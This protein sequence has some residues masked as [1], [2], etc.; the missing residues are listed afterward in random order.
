MFGFSQFTVDGEFRSRMAIDHGYKMP[1]KPGTDIVLSFD[2]RTRLRLN[3]K[4]EKFSTRFTLQDARVWGGDNMYNSTGVEGNSDAFGVYEAWVELRLK[5]NNYL[6][7]GRQEWN[8]DDMRILSR[9]NWWAAGLSYD[10]ILFRS[11]NKAE[12]LFLD[13]G[14][15]YNNN[16][17]RIGFVDNSLWPDSKLK[18]M[19][20]LNLKQDFDEKLTASLMFTLAGR[21]IVEDNV[22]LGTGTYGINIKYNKGKSIYNGLF[23]NVSGYYQ[24][25]KDMA[26][27]NGEYKS[28]SAY[29]VAAELGLRALKN[30]F[31]VSVGMELISG[32][33]Y[34]KNDDKYNSVR[35]SFDLLYSARNPYYG[36]HMNY[37]LVQESSK[38]GTKG[39]GY[40]DPYVKLKYV[41]NKKSTVGLAVFRPSLST[42]V[43]STT[44]TPIPGEDVE[45]WKGS[46]GLHFDLG[47]TYKY[48]KE[49]I[50]KFG[51]SYAHVSEMKYEMVYS[52]DYD[53][54]KFDKAKN[55]F[56]WAMLIVKPKFFDSEKRK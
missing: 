19:N 13:I 31:E 21:E 33:D 30:K 55:Y 16:G 5:N 45:Y 42:K 20:F 4:N 36:G 6:R 40:F 15:S 2:Q 28:I 44:F 14:V 48:S 43:A 10:G 18:T 47:Y 41:I 26:I 34:S 22:I 8:Y 52:N 9:R 25:G 24:S 54:A 3:Y 53:P 23:F 37:F 35:H 38:V 51:F 27:Y 32:R 49:V 1:V 11:Y 12:D 56:A 39:G 17:R 46:L 29:L 50:V 7:V